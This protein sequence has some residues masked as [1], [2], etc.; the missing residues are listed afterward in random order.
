[1]FKNLILGAFSKHSAKFFHNGYF[2]FI[3]FTYLFIYTSNNDQINVSLS[4]VKCCFVEVRFAISDLHQAISFLDEF[5]VALSHRECVSFS[6]GSKERRTSPLSSLGSYKINS[7]FFSTN[8][9]S[10]KNLF[11]SCCDVLRKCCVLPVG[12][13]IAEKDL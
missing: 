9:K 10:L 11:I 2:F 12:L 1:M 13:F 8:A 5:F 4:V 6:K 3:A 7:L